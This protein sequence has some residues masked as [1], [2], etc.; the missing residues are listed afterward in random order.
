MVCLEVEAKQRSITYNWPAGNS[1]TAAFV[2][3]GSIV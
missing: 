3:S 1:D 2:S